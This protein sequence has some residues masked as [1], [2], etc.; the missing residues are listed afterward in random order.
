MNGPPWVLNCPALAITRPQPPP[1]PVTLS[2]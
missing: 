2:P 1:I